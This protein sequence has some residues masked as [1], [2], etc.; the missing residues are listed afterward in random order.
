MLPDMRNVAAKIANDA[1][2]NLAGVHVVS[3]GPVFAELVP[4]GM[5][6]SVIVIVPERG[7]RDFAPRHVMLDVAPDP[8]MATGY[9]TALIVALEEFFGR[10]QVFGDELTL[11]HHWEGRDE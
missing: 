6:Y 10:V 2:E 5:Q 1:S 9:L 11:A 7:G 3:V 4:G 8:F